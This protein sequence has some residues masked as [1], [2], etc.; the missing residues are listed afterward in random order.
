VHGAVKHNAAAL[1]FV[2]NHPAGN[3]QPSDNDK[4]ITPDIV[5][6]GNIMHI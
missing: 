5:F 4:E 3:P 1:I 2:Y 6:A